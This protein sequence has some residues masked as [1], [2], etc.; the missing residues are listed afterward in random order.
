MNDAS[1]SLSRPPDAAPRHVWDTDDEFFEE[2]TRSHDMLAA[3]IERRENQITALQL[4]LE[5]IVDSPSYRTLRRIRPLWLTLIPPHSRRRRI[6]VHIARTILRARAHGLRTWID[7]PESPARWHVHTNA[8]DAHEPIAPPHV[9]V[10][11]LNDEL[12]A[13][14]THWAAEQTWPHVDVVPC[15]RSAVQRERWGEYVCVGSRDLLQQP[16]TWIETNML[17]MESE[18]LAFTLTLRSLPIWLA[19]PLRHCIIP[20]SPNLPLLRCLARADCVD[21]ALQLTFGAW[22]AAREAQP[23]QETTAV[24]R[25]LRITTNRRERFSQLPLHGRLEQYPTLR[26]EHDRFFLTQR[27]PQPAPPAHRAPVH[28]L[29]RMPPAPDP[30]PTVVVFLPFLAMG[31]AERIAL[32]VIRSL[33]AHIRFVVVAT[34]PH[35]GSLGSTADRFRALTPFV[36]TADDF[37]PHEQSLSFLTYLIERFTPRC[38]YLANGSAWL[39]DA[40]PRIRRRF[41]DIRLVNQV[42]DHR[43]GWIARYDAALAQLFDANIGTSKKICDAY[44]QAGVPA[45]RALLIEHPIDVAA[46]DSSRC[47]HFGADV[48]AAR[49]ARALLGEVPDGRR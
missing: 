33:T 45:S 13:A 16:A 35:D 14:L 4:E 46:F 23:P 2:L 40:L 20:G 17:A 38:L 9:S 7:P 49:Y 1:T 8:D 37:L 44:I 47:D 43:A 48:I 27:E 36:Y 19:L 5:R 42:Y 31:G 21:D 30:R 29:F 22:L 28:R 10:L 3:E 39:F 24:G 32:D 25:I 41:P 15:T 34:D 18:Q 6:V 12:H 11:C 26:C